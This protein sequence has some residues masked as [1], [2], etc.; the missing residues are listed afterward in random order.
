MSWNSTPSETVS[1]PEM[2]FHKVTG[3]DREHTA[4]VTSN[5]WVVP[6]G[7]DLSPANTFIVH[8]QKG[9][10]RIRTDIYFAMVNSRVSGADLET[11]AC[12]VA[13]HLGERDMK[14]HARW[15]ANNGVR[16]TL[17]DLSSFQGDDLVA[18]SDP[19]PL[20]FFENHSRGKRLI[21]G[22][23]GNEYAHY[24]L[25]QLVTLWAFRSWVNNNVMSLNQLLYQGGNF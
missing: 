14:N 23:R 12:R 9:D 7:V 17:D 19:K 25:L 16:L 3:V 4:V 6:I 5:M 20:V 18:I 13:N 11:F 1:L 21:M 22:Q 10:R 2:L 15:H 8:N 24:R